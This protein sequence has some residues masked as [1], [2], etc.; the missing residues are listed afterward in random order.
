MTCVVSQRILYAKGSH[1]L[2]LVSEYQLVQHTA[3]STRK[4]C[5]GRLLLFHGW[6]SGES[7]PSA[8][9][10]YGRSK[11]FCKSLRIASLNPSL[12]NT[13]MTDPSRT[14]TIVSSRR[15]PFTEAS[16]STPVE[17]DTMCRNSSRRVGN[18]HVVA[19]PA[20]EIGQASKQDLRKVD[21]KGARI[22]GG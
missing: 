9:L 7:D 13:L 12:R 3:I 5:G 19:S 15:S 4:S 20:S 6:V 14:C 10:W 22:D 1:F 16:I 2:T 17:G 8:C 18:E 21:S 11:N